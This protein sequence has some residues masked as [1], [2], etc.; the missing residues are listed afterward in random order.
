M[1]GNESV[2]NGHYAM[3]VQGWSGTGTAT[4][5]MYAAE[6]AADGT[7]KITGGQDQLNPYSNS[8]YAGAGVIALASSYSVGPTNGTVLYFIDETGNVPPIVQVF[9]P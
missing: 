4:P 8:A 3:M 5:I 7:G 6:F 2:L 9:E 1:G